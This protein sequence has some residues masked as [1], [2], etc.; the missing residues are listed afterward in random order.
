[1]FPLSPS[2]HG[3]CFICTG[4]E[5]SALRSQLETLRAINSKDLAAEG[6][7]HKKPGLREDTSLLGGC[8]GVPGSGSHYPL[9]DKHQLPHWGGPVT[10]WGTFTCCPSPPFPCYL[11]TRGGEALGWCLLW[12]LAGRAAALQ[13]LS[14]VRE[15]RAPLSVTSGSC[16]KQWGVYC[17]A[18]WINSWYLACHKF[19][20]TEPFQFLVGVLLR[21]KAWSSQNDR[22]RK[23][24]ESTDIAK[25]VCPSY[26]FSAFSS[27]PQTVP[28]NT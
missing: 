9:C 13:S 26:T 20:H 15:C 2:V 24:W 8:R 17:K 19:S 28:R 7:G 14:V 25:T 21:A 22:V 1:M 27:L 5:V 10:K 6:R 12:I 16:I 18:K 23:P 11:T 3:F 4:P